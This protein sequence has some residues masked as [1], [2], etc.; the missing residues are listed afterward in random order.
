LLVA[1]K[2]Q[3]FQL[4]EGSAGFGVGEAKGALEVSGAD[5]VCGEAVGLDFGHGATFRETTSSSVQTGR[6]FR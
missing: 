4:F 6:K 2:P 5:L 3:G 1:D